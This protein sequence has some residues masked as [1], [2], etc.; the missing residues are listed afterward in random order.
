MRLVLLAILLTLVT[1]RYPPRLF[2]AGLG[3]LWLFLPGLL[4]GLRSKPGT[5]A[6]IGWSF[7]LLLDLLSMEPLGLHAFVFGA[8]AYVLA[9]ARGVM[10][11][12]HP[13]TQGIAAFLLTALV[14]SFLLLRLEEAGAFAIT[15]HAPAALLTAAFTGVG[16][17]LLAWVDKKVGLLAGFRERDGG[18]QA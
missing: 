14:G 5:A 15:A 7:G 8:A 11:S 12:D 2:A 10:F 3:P 1:V 13:T 6:A 4:A 17:P 18:V 16:F 9:R